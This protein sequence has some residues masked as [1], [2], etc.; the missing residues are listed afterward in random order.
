MKFKINQALTII[1]AIAI[2]LAILA[3]GCE[4]KEAPPPPPPKIVIKEPPTKPVVP[5]T[6]AATKEV[7]IDPSKMSTAEIEAAISKKYNFKIYLDQDNIE[8]FIELTEFNA[9]CA[10]PIGNLFGSGQLTINPTLP[11]EQK[12]PI[13]RVVSI[14][15]DKMGLVEPEINGVGKM[16]QPIG[17]RDNKVILQN[18]D[19]EITGAIIVVCRPLTGKTVGGENWSLRLEQDVAKKFYK[20]ELVK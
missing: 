14:E 2:A 10:E 3:T 12:V 4:K 15:F 13:D 1:F 19:E 8:E 20:I 18:P 9:A 6:P 7:S 5:D 17:F 11:N 16:N